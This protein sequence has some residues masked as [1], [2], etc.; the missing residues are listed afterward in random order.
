MCG[1]LSD[2]PSEFT[3]GTPFQSKPSFKINYDRVYTH[4]QNEYAQ[5]LIGDTGLLWSA[6]NK[7]ASID[8]ADRKSVV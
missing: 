6:S 1:S 2:L 5:V 8:F 3:N 7:K 4:T